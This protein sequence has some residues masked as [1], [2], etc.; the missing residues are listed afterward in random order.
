MERP[1][2]AGPPAGG[3]PGA[4][5]VRR[6]G[7]RHAREDKSGA[8]LA[9]A[10]AAAGFDRGRAAWWCRGR[11]STAVAGALR[12][13]RPEASPVLERQRPGA[14]ASGPRD[15][16]PEGNG[17]GRVI[18]REAPGLAEA[19]RLVNPLEA[20]LSRAVAGTR[21]IG[22]RP[23]AATRRGSTK[24]ADRVPR[25]RWSTS[26]PKTRPSTSS[27]Q[28]PHRRRR[29]SDLNPRGPR[30]AFSGHATSRG[31]AEC[32]SSCG[33][34]PAARRRADPAVRGPGPC[35]GAGPGDLARVWSQ[36]TTV[37]QHLR[38]AGLGWRVALNLS[39]SWFRRRASR[40]AGPT[41]ESV[42]PPD[43]ALG[44]DY[45]RPMAV[46]TAVGGCRPASGR[47]GS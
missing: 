47:S 5:G 22:A 27:P 9:E 6:R 17:P 8:A 37:R 2:D 38:P 23:G 45:R 26:G 41:P 30:C 7:G 11:R 25:A 21:G 24:G 32:G 10:L 28:S 20:V 35:R 18:E 14:P 44:A 34:S 3:R 16:T 1:T 4:H 15:L 46:R 42:R 33:R 31:L 12:T 36:W 39:S 43:E 19:K 40:S 13:R 29:T